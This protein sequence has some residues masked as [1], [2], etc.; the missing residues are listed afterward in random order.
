[1]ANEFKLDLPPPPYQS[2]VGSPG[3]NGYESLPAC[4]CVPMVLYLLDGQTGLI[5]S[6]RT[7]IVISEGP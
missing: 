1:M 4:A 2:N 3:L 7:A 5:R 6:S